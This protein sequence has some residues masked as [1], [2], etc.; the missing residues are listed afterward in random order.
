MTV[1]IISQLWCS[2]LSC[3][4]QAAVVAV[5]DGT[6]RDHKES[7]QHGNRRAHLQQ[8]PPSQSRHAAPGDTGDPRMQGMS[9][10][11][12][13]HQLR[14]QNPFTG[15]E[16]SQALFQQQRGKHTVFAP[17][18]CKEEP[19]HHHHHYNSQQPA[20]R[21][22]TTA[23]GHRREHQQQQHSQQATPYGEHDE[24]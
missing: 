7:Q 23:S 13:V 24:K 8:L 18:G 16:P 20:L 6:Q 2:C 10:G 5:K 15:D 1:L 11:T 19:H 9:P 14:Y 21:P 17:S 22:S 3:G 12:A 4:L